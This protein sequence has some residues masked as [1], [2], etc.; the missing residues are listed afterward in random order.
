MIDLGP[1]GFQPSLLAK[2]VFYIGAG[3]ALDK[4]VVVGDEILGQEQSWTD[5]AIQGPGVCIAEGAYER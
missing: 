4:S 2:K 3:Q 1:E 5:R